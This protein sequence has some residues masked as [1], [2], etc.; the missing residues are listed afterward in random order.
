MCISNNIKEQIKISKFFSLLDKHIELWERKLQLY[1]LKKKYHLYNM[2]CSNNNLPFLR[3]KEFKKNLV[4]FSYINDVSEIKNGVGFPIIFQEKSDSKISFYKVSDLNQ[5]SREI[6]SLFSIDYK[7]I[8]RLNS[9]PFFKPSICFAK[10]GEACKLNRKKVIS[11]NFYFID[12]NMSSLIPFDTIEFYYFYYFL[13]KLNFN[14]FIK[15]S[16]LPSIDIDMLKN[17]KIFYPD[18]K[19]QIKISKFFLLLDN[20]IKLSQENIDNL[21][22]K[23]LFYINKMFI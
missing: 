9:K 11:S 10:I 4:N 22:I 2:F 16:N 14:S 21:K 17:H 3:F 13:C 12:N 7:N 5:S 19:E 23:K 1:L 8:E 20:N 15:T 6:N 18:I